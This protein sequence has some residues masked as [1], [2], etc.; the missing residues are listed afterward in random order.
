[1]IYFYTKKYPTTKEKNFKN[2][3][4]RNHIG[5]IEKMR[6]KGAKVKKVIY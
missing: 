4:E 2:E 5:M 3:R 1:M 6:H